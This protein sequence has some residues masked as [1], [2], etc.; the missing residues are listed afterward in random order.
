MADDIEA[1]VKKKIALEEGNKELKQ[2]IK[3]LKLRLDYKQKQIDVLEDKIKEA[4]NIL[5]TG[6][7]VRIGFYRRGK[8]KKSFWEL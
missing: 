3:D 5:V 2:E 4:S 7:S 1:I 6:R 8:R